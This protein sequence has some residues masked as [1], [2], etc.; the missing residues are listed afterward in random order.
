M[1][2]STTPRPG[3]PPRRSANQRREA[4]LFLLVVFASPADGGAQPL[5]VFVQG[6]DVKAALARA[7]GELDARGWRDVEVVSAKALPND[8]AEEDDAFAREAMTR[9]RESGF[10]MIRYGI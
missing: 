1:V 10:D 6:V 7:L 8:P 9:A 3:A 5:L 2:R 4:E